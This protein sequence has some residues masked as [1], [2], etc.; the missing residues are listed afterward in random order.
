MLT[1]IKHFATQRFDPFINC[2]DDPIFN[3]DAARQ[4]LLV[5]LV[6]VLD[7]LHDRVQV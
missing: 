3:K 7:Q 2:D 5:L 1:V 6:H 4:D